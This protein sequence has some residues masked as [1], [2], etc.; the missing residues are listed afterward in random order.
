MVVRHQTREKSSHMINIL[1]HK[2]QAIFSAMILLLAPPPS[3]L[4]LLATP[5]SGHYLS[6]CGFVKTVNNQ[7]MN[8]PHPGKPS[9]AGHGWFLLDQQCFVG[10]PPS[11]C[12]QSQCF[13]LFVVFCL[14]ANQ[15][16]FY[17]TNILFLAVVINS[18]CN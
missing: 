14:E 8:G 18:K 11:Q 4:L 17:Q 9:D 13:F 10:R 5:E 3:L 12:V 2:P 15:M 1:K 7:P 6:G 16:R